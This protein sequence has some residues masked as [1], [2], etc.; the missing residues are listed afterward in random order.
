[1]ANRTR[2][3][4][5]RNAIDYAYG[6]GGP[7][8]PAPLLVQQGNGAT[9]AQTITLQFGFVTLT[10]GTVINNPITITTPITIGSGSNAETVT[11][12]A[13]SNPTPSVYGSCQV[14]ANFANLHGIGDP[15]SSG[16]FGL[17]EA[18]VDAH[19]LGGLVAVD[20]AWTAIGGLTGT[21]TGNKGWTNV[22]VLDWRG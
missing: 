6:S 1:M 5:L 22:G 16:T 21:I 7:N 3:A 12:S 14:T 18:V 2:F 4:G 17:E 11:P 13:V 9:G 8:A 15:I 10:D 20:G 19:V